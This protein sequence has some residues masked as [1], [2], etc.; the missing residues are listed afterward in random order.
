[1]TCS[2]PELHKTIQT[3][4]SMALYT[5]VFMNLDLTIIMKLDS[6]GFSSYSSSPHFRTSVFNSKRGGSF[7]ILLDIA[8]EDWILYRQISLTRSWK[9]TFESPLIHSDIHL[10]LVRC[11]CTEINS[12]FSLAARSLLD[13]YQAQELPLFSQLHC[14]EQTT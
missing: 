4:W 10:Q 5:T 6:L 9:E 11:P 2:F 13:C 7:L 8:G 12:V 1:M 3:F 14:N